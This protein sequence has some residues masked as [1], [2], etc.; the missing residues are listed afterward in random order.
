MKRFYKGAGVTEAPEGFGVALDGK[1]VR[2]PAKRS[3]AVPTR[4]L[5]EAITAPEHH[6]AA[7]SSTQQHPAP[8][9][10]APNEALTFVPTY[11]ALGAG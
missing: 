8:R 10:T 7:S 2:T 4:A 11:H 6:P 5:A 3:L 9:S 1:P